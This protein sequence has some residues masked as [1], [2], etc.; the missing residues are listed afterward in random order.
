MG[1]RVVIISSFAEAHLIKCQ[2]PNLVNIFNPDVIIYNEGVFPLGPE[3]K[4][5]NFNGEKWCFNKHTGVGFDFKETLDA[6]RQSE[7]QYTSIKFRIHHMDYSK[8]DDKSADGAYMYAASY[9]HKIDIERGDII[10]PLEPDV[11]HHE[12]QKNLINKAIDTL[13]IGQGIASNWIDFLQTQYYTEKIHRVNNNFKNR[14]IAYR[15]DNMD[16]YKSMLYS[17]TSQNYT[18]L[19]II[20]DINTYHY[21][22]FRPFPYKQLR[23]ELI[24]RGDPQYWV[25][26]E[27]GLEQI[28]I[29]SI[30]KNFKPVVIRPSRPDPMR[31]AVPITM[32]DGHPIEIQSHPNYIK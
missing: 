25:D 3:S 22:W 6:I 20:N 28:Y 21:A 24:H 5:K 17:F 14:K 29:N 26:F 8:C 7:K 16:N 10:L 11:F 12:S 30:N 18:S 15:F 31:Y 27:R 4:T 13:E 2:I 32:F 23:Y 19:R 1:K 9:F